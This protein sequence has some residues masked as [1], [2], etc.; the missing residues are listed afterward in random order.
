MTITILEIIH[1]LVFYESEREIEFRGWEGS[2]RHY[3]GGRKY[4]LLF[5][6]FPGIAR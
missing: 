4:Q 1:R 3:R 5:G 2:E 6:R